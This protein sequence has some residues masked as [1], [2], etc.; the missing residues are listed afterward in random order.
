MGAE[1]AHV[2]IKL[3]DGLPRI[4]AIGD[5]TVP[6]CGDPNRWSASS[7]PVDDPVGTDT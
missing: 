4:V 1:L 2:E 5:R 3:L 7:G 6:D